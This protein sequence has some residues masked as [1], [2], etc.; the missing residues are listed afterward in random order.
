MRPVLHFLHS[1][2]LGMMLIQRPVALAKEWPW[3]FSISNVRQSR[4][5]L[6]LP[7]VEDD[8]EPENEPLENDLPHI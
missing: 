5:T 3:R 7:S 4:N 1:E 6:W 8:M 2:E